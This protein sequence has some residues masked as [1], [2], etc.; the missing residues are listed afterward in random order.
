[1]QKE[2]K[3]NAYFRVYI[4]GGGC[5]GFQYGFKIEHIIGPDDIRISA[6]EIEVVID[7]LSMQYLEGC[8]INFKQDLQGARFIAENP[9][10][11]ST[12]GCG[13]SFA[14]S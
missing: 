8:T 14:V 11:E 3:E 13:S 6:G 1:M 5:Y 7:P 9:N 2:N 4:T 12:C 10:A